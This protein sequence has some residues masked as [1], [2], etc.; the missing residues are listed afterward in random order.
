MFSTFEGIL[1]VFIIK[2]LEFRM[3]EILNFHTCM[4][5]QHL[6]QQIVMVKTSWESKVKSMEEPGQKKHYTFVYIV[7]SL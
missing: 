5:K 2:F 7:L 1:Q 6:S 3:W 4:I